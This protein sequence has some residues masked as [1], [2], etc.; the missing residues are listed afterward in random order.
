MNIKNYLDKKFLISERNSSLRGEFIAG[1]T[2]FLAIC[3]ILIV[4]GRMFS[5]MGISFGAIY[6]ATGITTILSTLLIGLYSN[7]PLIVSTALGVNAF[8]V[9]TACMSLGFTY[10]NALIIVFLDGIL[11]VI[12]SI[13]GLRKIF[14]DSLPKC[15]TLAISVGIG[16]FIAFVG[17]QSSSIV[18]FDTSTCVKLNYFSILEGGGL[19]LIL[20]VLTLISLVLL[21]AFKRKNIQIGIFIT[22]IIGT[23][24]YYIF[25]FIFPN[26]IKLHIQ[27]FN[28][29]N[30][31]RDFWNISC[32]ACFRG[33]DFS[34][35]LSI[36]GHNIKSLIISLISLFWTFSILSMF[37]TVGSIMSCVKVAGLDSKNNKSVERGVIADAFSTCLA[38]LLG[39]SNQTVFV[40]STAGIG[41]GGRTGLTSIFAA[42]GFIIAL[43]FLPIAQMVPPCVYS[44]VLIFIGLF[45]AMD[46]KDLNWSDPIEAFVS[47]V[48]I[49]VMP[50]TYN[51]SYGIGFGLITYVLLKISTGKIKELNLIT[52]IVFIL[53]V[54]L[55][56][57]IR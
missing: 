52:W 14:F 21:L 39:T 42:L 24:L 10:E 48:T 25:Y 46:I 13:T 44:S 22:L 17:F 51:V 31:F 11:F 40:E 50:F 3:Y 32:F 36:E 38:G 4:N 54:G 53:F 30:G 16:L 9:Y 7:L 49:V 15:V 43:F 34:H 26:L 47:F 12:L 28:I 1:I 8:F 45:M 29:I 19:N 23:V 6:I 27:D 41:V 35:Y 55:I 37:D 18:T 2:S 33:F 57:G 5:E 56:F 20:C